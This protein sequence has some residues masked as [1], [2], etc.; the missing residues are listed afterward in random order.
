MGCQPIKCPASSDTAQ[1]A[2]YLLHL[3]CG[4]LNKCHWQWT[5]TISRRII[6]PYLRRK[7]ITV[8]QLTD[9]RERNFLQLEQVI[10]PRT[11]KSKENHYHSQPAI[12]C[13]LLML[14][15]GYFWSLPVLLPNCSGKHPPHTAAK[16]VQLPCPWFSSTGHCRAIS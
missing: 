10:C 1:Y 6:G 9:N 11:V 14:K 7:I 16:P 2:P 13:L 8:N 12:C 4:D 3:L 5:A 15:L